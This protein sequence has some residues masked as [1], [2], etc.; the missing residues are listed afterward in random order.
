VRG[1]VLTAAEMRAAEAALF[2]MGMASFEV[3]RRAGEQAATAIRAD[4]PHARRIAVFCGPGNNGGD[5]YIVAH[6]LVP[7]A[8]VVEVFALDAPRT[9]DAQRAA[10]LWGSGTR[11]V[12]AFDVTA[13]DLVVDALFGIGLSRALEGAAADTV[14]AINRAGQGG[15]P[16]IAL[17]IAS[18]IDADNG[19][20]RGCAVEAR[21]TITFHALKRGHV[22][23]PGRS[24]SGAV[25]VA[26]IGLASSDGHAIQCNGPAL[27]SAHLPRLDAGAHKYLRGH[28][29]VVAGGLEGV[30]AARL[31]ARA[32][33]RI[34]AGLVTIATPREALV[35]HAARGPD[36]LMAR[37]FDDGDFSP[38][39]ADARRNA[40]LIGPAFGLGDATRDAVA[41]VLAVQRASV[42]DADALTA[43]TGK[44]ADLA[45]LIAGNDRVVLTPHAGEF[46]RLFG[47]DD[48]DKITRTIAAARSVGAIVV[49]KGADTVIASPDGRAAVN[50]NGTPYLAT[51][52]TGDV[53]AG[54]IAGLL[55]QGMVPF[56]AACACVYLHSAAGQ[57]LVE[58]RGGGFIADDL[59][60]AIRL[61]P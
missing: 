27:W 43:F 35:A 22:L 51:A 4:Y 29:L 55:A 28:A 5:G 26:D 50:V 20:V 38:E 40:L 24:H 59:A 17:D 2:A 49:H 61:A 39:L 57:R 36:A 10:S 47:T 56:D 46:M 15:T 25:H 54:M 48:A 12:S 34:G 45:R 23:E 19:R 18:G 8:D 16:V 60:D 52:G 7:H 14:H 21:Q 11:S 58:Q 9:A 31:A 1:P 3:M 32:A 44:A 37:A 13:F 53:L 33:L 41:R 30:G 42:L 6:A